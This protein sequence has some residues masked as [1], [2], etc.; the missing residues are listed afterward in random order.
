M[1]PCVYLK[2][3]NFFKFQKRAIQPLEL[4]HFCKIISVLCIFVRIARHLDLPSSLACIR[5]D[6]RKCA[7]HREKDDTYFF[8]K[9]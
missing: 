3:K 7:A 4:Y 9:I 8:S 2:K 6:L 5:S 1:G